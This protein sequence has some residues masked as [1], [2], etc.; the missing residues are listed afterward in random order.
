[1]IQKI[2]QKSCARTSLVVVT[3]FIVFMPVPGWS[4]ETYEHLYKAS[5]IL[6][7][8]IRSMA[9]DFYAST[10]GVDSVQP[11]ARQPD[12]RERYYFDAL[13]RTERY[14]AASTNI[15]IEGFIGPQLMSRYEYSDN[16]LAVHRHD[17]TVFGSAGEWNYRTDSMGRRIGDEW[18]GRGVNHVVSKRTYFHDSLGRLFKSKSLFGMDENGNAEECSWR[19][20]IWDNLS[21]N[22]LGLSPEELAFCNYS[23]EYQD[24]NGKCARRVDYV[25]SSLAGST[26]FSYDRTGKPVK[27][28]MLSADSLGVE[29]FA[30]IFYEP[31][32]VVKIEIHGKGTI[33]DAK[34][35]QLATV[36]RS[37]VVDNWVAWRLLREIRILQGGHE[38]GRYVF[39]YNDRT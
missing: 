8:K 6:K 34:L 2:V 14:E 36:S 30:E 38:F 39:L 5:D 37:F 1:M 24:A 13:G 32:G 19:F 20:F 28:E 29:S 23:L 10:Q 3:L 18:Y 35:S 7:H 25:S 11:L 33:Y 9:V 22:S 27:V 16:G 15:R 26:A 31:N 21:T 4:Q 12:Y 17:T